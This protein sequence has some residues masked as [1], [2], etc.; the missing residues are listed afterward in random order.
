MQAV[1]TG[2][3]LNQEKFIGN[4][5]LP[6]YCITLKHERCRLRQK[7]FEASAKKYNW[8]FQF[9]FGSDCLDKNLNR[10]YKEQKCVETCFKATPAEIACAMSHRNLLKKI[11]RDKNEFTIICEDD[12]EISRSGPQLIPSHEFDILFLNSRC[13]H[14]KFGELWG[15][16]C[17]GTDSYLVTLRGAKKIVEMLDKSQVLRLPLDM[18]ILSQSL[19]LRKMGHHICKHQND[20]FSEIYAY[21]S[22]PIS[23]V[24]EAHESLL[25][26]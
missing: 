16:S 11:I 15:T 12:V 10:I 7:S 19:S 2:D 26:H 14:N 13:R 8:D 9:F 20:K 3:F 17:C 18:L 6:M 5:Y 4:N 25:A 23:K 22:E 21:H 24:N 1:C